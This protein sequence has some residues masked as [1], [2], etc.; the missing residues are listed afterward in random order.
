MPEIQSLSFWGD[1]SII[2]L[3]YPIPLFERSTLRLDNLPR[4]TKLHHD[5]FAKVVFLGNTEHGSSPIQRSGNCTRC[6]LGRGTS[7]LFSLNLWPTKTR[8]HYVI[9]DCPFKKGIVGF[10]FCTLQDCFLQVFRNFLNRSWLQESP[11]PAFALNQFIDPLWNPNFWLVIFIKRITETDRLGRWIDRV[12]P[13]SRIPNGHR[14]PSFKI[15]R[16]VHQSPSTS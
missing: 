10:Y 1:P 14:R 12:D 16:N 8:N 5:L 7:P 4:F 9:P 3:F 13:C 15:H 2:I 11:I 6:S